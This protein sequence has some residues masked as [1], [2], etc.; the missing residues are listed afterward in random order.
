ML[1]SLLSLCCIATILGWLRLPAVAQITPDASL[2][3]ERTT[4]SPANIIGGG[5]QRGANLFHS[6]SDFNISDGQRI[7]F[8]NPTGVDRIFA[9]V[10]GGTRSQ[11]FGTLGVLGSAN[12]FLINPNGIFFGP[13]ARLDISGSF[14]VSTADRL[15][16]DNGE[17]SATTPQAPPLLTISAPIGLQYRG[18][19]AIEVQGATLKVQPN[20]RLALLGGDVSLED[21]YLESPGGQIEI[22][23]QN[24]S[25]QDSRL[26]AGLGLQATPNAVAGN[27]ILSA[28]DRLSLNSSSI[29]N[30][31]LSTAVGKG[32]DI[33]LNAGSLSIT[34]NSLISTNIDGQGNGGD[35][36][37]QVR[38]AMVLDG[39]SIASQVGSGAVGNAGDITIET[40]S[41]TLV[42]RFSFSE[43]QGVRGE[44]FV[45]AS[46]QGQGD[47]GKIT[48][49]AQDAVLMDGGRISSVIGIDSS[50]N[51]NDIN[52]TAGSVDLK[53]G[54]SL[55]TF[56]RGQGNGGD[57]AIAVRDAMVLTDSNIA[58]QVEFNSVGNAGDI[59]I[60]AGSFTLGAGTATEF[61]SF[62]GEAFVNASTGGQGNAGKITIAAQDTVLI[63]GG[64]MSSVV[65]LDSSGSGNDINITARSVDLKKR[66]TLQTFNLGQGG[67]AGN[68]IIASETFTS[69]GDIVS[70]VTDAQ[71]TGGN[72]S[73]TANSLT[74]T[75]GTIEALT[76]GRG[77]AGSVQLRGRDRIVLDE[78]GIST[79]VRPVGDG[80]F[81][82]GNGGNITVSTNE[83]T[84]AR[85]SR[86]STSTSGIGRAGDLNV[87]A[88]AA[89]E[90]SGTQQV[91]NEQGDLVEQTS[92][93]FASTDG[94]GN[95]GTIRLKTNQFV[96]RDR[97]QIGVSSTSDGETGNLAISANSLRLDQGR[98]TAES[99]SGTGGNLS[100]N[101]E[102]VLLLRRG[103]SI[104][105]T[106][107]LAQGGGNGGNINIA[108]G[109]VLAVPSENSSITANAFRGNGGNIAI[110][111]QGIYGFELG[112]RQTNLSKITASS[113]FGIDGTV[114]IN[115]LAL[116]PVQSIGELLIRFSSPSIAQGCQTS[117]R[118]ARFVNQGRGGL[119]PSPADPLTTETIW[120]DWE[121]IDQRQ[122]N[123]PEIVEA[124][125]W[126]KQSDG[127]V[128]LVANL[129]RAL[130]DCPVLQPVP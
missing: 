80:T 10:I 107:G 98:I 55:Q 84:L 61:E 91:F 109:F 22:T 15:I 38:D 102:N 120:Q 72:V 47:S 44:A 30:G 112:D 64:R 66:A 59:T 110:A 23:G 73:I 114:S 1:K 12:L 105:T 49:V 89:I 117:S 108:S 67:S 11:I 7:D 35:I 65:G 3:T 70:T 6:F 57:I 78:S 127:T 41:F 71:G 125:G 8:A 111:T 58:S 93:L 94:P 128:A 99:A 25:L 39:S 130:N 68:I 76:F 14:V 74:F 50:G 18:T 51:S 87:V 53:Q 56:N 81:A 75:D 40:G 24:I 5:A 77:N 16:F 113:Q 88:N 60:K 33:R 26:V 27:I 79:E 21:A 97:A 115:N 32:G 101:L 2:G 63:D 100:F 96:I 83:L 13:N 9:R 126:V 106:A 34:D 17:F 4:L 28:T 118:T 103:G 43:E 92:G 45:D 124:Q 31:I 95:A 20:Q 119:S 52:I 69:T 82:Q 48:I 116:N 104:S 121:L 42:D 86:L 54:A 129:D 85:G 90:L 29:S 37:I 122:A 36:A 19:G 123:H 46:T 62:L